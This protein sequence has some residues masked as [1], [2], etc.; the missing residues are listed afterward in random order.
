MHNYAGASLSFPVSFE[1]QEGTIP[2][3]CVTLFEVLAGLEREVTVNFSAQP[4]S[5]AEGIVFL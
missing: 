2:E 1:F 3:V 5:A 4:G